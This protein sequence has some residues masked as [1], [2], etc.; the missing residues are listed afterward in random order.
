MRYFPVIND[1]FRDFFDDTYFQPAKA[2][3]MPC[4]IK[5]T[6]DKYEMAIEV[7]GFKKE[8]ISIE[9]E[10]GYLTVSAST[11]N[12]SEETDENGRVIRRERHTGSCSR[13]FYV[14]PD[15]TQKDINATLE[16]G[17]LVI[18]LPKEAPKK[19]EEKKYIEIL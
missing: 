1:M 16:N 3:A 11:H 19:V 15:Y 7:P 12:E 9:L 13:R 14:G 6:E 8:D 5:E 10:Q 18:T 17:E 4:D 2:H